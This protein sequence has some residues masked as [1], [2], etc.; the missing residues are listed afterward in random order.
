MD[1]FCRPNASVDLSVVP[2]NEKMNLKRPEYERHCYTGWAEKL[3]ARHFNF[4]RPGR[5]ENAYR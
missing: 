1:E 5:T 4:S 3:R 2:V